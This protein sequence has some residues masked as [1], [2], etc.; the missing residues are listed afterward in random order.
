MAATVVDPPPPPEAEERANDHPPTPDGVALRRLLA[1]ATLTPAQAGLLARDLVTG[2][3]RLRRDG[4]QPGRVT[5][6]STVVSADGTLQVLPETGEHP[7]DWA[8]TT[9]S[10]AALVRQTVGNARRG[11]SRRRSEAAALAE[12]VDGPADDLDDLA[13]KVDE[14]VSAVLEPGDEPRTRR[15]LA[16]L[17]AGTKGRGVPSV[18]QPPVVLPTEPPV[19]RAVTLA[20]DSWRPSSRRR[21]HRRSKLRNRRTWLLIVLVVAVGAG[22]AW[23]I[24]RGWSELQ[25]GWNAVFT[26]EQAPQHLA[27]VSPPASPSSAAKP[28]EKRTQPRPVDRVAPRQAG[29]VTQVKVAAAEPCRRGAVCPVRV[30]VYLRPEAVTR[31]VSW[32]LRVVDRCTGKT[33]PRSG[34]S[35]FAEPWWRQVYGLSRAALPKGRALA[36]IAVTKAPARAASKPLLIPARHATC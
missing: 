11:G 8:S 22:L 31:Q 9:A 21:W 7:E 17:V 4:H 36:V 10:A 30:D 35:V 27:P 32:S 14:A 25:R 15:E 16:V 1:V 29:A 3:D 18:D 23:G 5:D 2:L 6:R 26:P 13:R 34:A 19:P 24:P 20:P 33:Y 12:R 28:A